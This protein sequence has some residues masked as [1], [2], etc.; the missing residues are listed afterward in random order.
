MPFLGSKNSQKTH[1][2]RFRFPGIDDSFYVQTVTPPEVEVQE[3]T[4][5]SPGNLPDIKTAGKMVTGDL[6]LELIRPT[7]DVND[8]GAWDKLASA[9]AGNPSDIFDVFFLDYLQANSV[10]VQQTFVGTNAWVKKIAYNDS[11]NKEDA[12]NVMM[13]V[14]LSVFTYYPADSASM[15]ALFGS[16][17]AGAIGNA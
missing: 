14:T 13:T 12:D 9:V 15:S 11:S 17:G 5:G 7:I 8:N 3:V 1:R 4:H 10:G 2:Y 16:S 6:V